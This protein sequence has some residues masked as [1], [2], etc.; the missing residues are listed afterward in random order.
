MP[1]HSKCW[2]LRVQTPMSR[3]SS[4]ATTREP[5]YDAMGIPAIFTSP[6][7]NDARIQGGPASFESTDKSKRNERSCTQLPDIDSSAC[8]AV[9]T[10]NFWRPGRT[11]NHHAPSRE[12]VPIQ[13]IP[14]T[15]MGGPNML[16]DTTVT[17]APSAGIVYLVSCAGSS[18]ASG[19]TPQFTILNWSLSQS[20]FD[21]SLRTGDNE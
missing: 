16:L 6:A 12:Y 8:S 15:F 20:T 9:A 7:A 1:H 17:A 21:P 11:K 2:R 14:Q 4:T 3:F 13:L 5:S 10:P 19:S 18:K